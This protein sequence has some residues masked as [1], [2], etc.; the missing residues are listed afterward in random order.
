M[1]S[2]GQDVYAGMVLLPGGSF[3]MGTPETKIVNLL[4]TYQIRHGDL[5]TFEVPQHTVTLDAFLID[6]YPVT[7]AQFKAFLDALPEG[8]PSTIP[9]SFTMEAI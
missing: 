5:F 3:Q 1:S 6:I 8:T 9:R 2:Q 4:R 7:N